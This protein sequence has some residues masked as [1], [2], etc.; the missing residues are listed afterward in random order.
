MKQKTEFKSGIYEHYKG[1]RYKVHGIVRHSESLEELVYY[2][3]L[4]ENSLG[5][6]WVRPKDMFFENVTIAGK[7]M[8]R[9]RFISEG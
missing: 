5:K 2:E 8:P 7:E 6:F 4:Y 3:C 9:F 1:M